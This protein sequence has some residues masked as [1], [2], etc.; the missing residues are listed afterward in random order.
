[1]EEI[2][3][4][5]KTPKSQSG[6]DEYANLIILHKNVHKL[7][8]ATQRDTISAILQK[9]QLKPAELK[10]LNSLRKLAGNEAIVLEQKKK[11]ILLLIR[12]RICK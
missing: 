9:V 4:H 8:H 2:H 1:M 7:V 10:K 6:G 5:H 11:K 3:C 12:M